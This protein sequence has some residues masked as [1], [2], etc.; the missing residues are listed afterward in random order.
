MAKRRGPTKPR[1]SN[2]GKN[3]TK[4][5]TGFTNKHGVGITLKEKKALESAVNRAN[6]KRKQILQMEE[7]MPRMLR[8]KPTGQ[9]L[10]DLR[11][12]GWE[13]DYAIRAK[14]K[15]LHQFKTR[16]EFDRYMG[17]LEKV[18]KKTYLEDRM[19]QYKANHMQAI[20]RELGDMGIVMKIR[21]MKPED[22]I[23]MVQQYED[24]M[25]IHY[26]Y[27]VDQKQQKINQIREALGMK[28][29]DEPDLDGEMYE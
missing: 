11:K 13:S 4:T 16:E 15:S 10:G 8:G 27:G 22:Y 6:R 18:N 2:R 23:K 19:R 7:N 5:P 28:T 26:I 20:K 9:T 29:I 25:E 3:L 24:V 17:Y 14:S 21:M 1:A 12:M